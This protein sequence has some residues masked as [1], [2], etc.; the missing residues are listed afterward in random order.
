MAPSLVEVAATPALP[1]PNKRAAMGTII[2]AFVFICISNREVDTLRT[3][4]TGLKRKAAWGESEYAFF[5]VKTVKA[6][7]PR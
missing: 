6:Y 4:I 1:T 5:E 3:S 7:Q 2:N